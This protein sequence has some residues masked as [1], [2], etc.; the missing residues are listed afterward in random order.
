[1]SK[2]VLYEKTI[3]VFEMTGA[4]ISGYFG[5]EPNIYFKNKYSNLVICSTLGAFIGTGIG[6]YFHH[7][8]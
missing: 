2:S 6:I 1:M 4:A 5:T 3:T 8:F 7:L